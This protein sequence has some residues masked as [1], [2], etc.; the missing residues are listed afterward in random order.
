MFLTVALQI[1][2]R[3]CLLR[4]AACYRHLNRK[5]APTKTTSVTFLNFVRSKYDKSVLETNR[6][7]KQSST[8]KSPE[9]PILLD[10]DDKNTNLLDA[11]AQDD[12]CLHD[13]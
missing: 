4:T 1:V 6:I 10:E 7:S 2:S 11:L 9:K 8:V 12:L 13:K 5:I 3:V